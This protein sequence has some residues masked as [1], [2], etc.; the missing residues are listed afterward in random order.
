MNRPATLAGWFVGLLLLSIVLVL[1]TNFVLDLADTHTDE[2]HV[3]CLSRSRRELVLFNLRLTI[4]DKIRLVVTEPE[5]GGALVEADIGM[6]IPASLPLAVSIQDTVLQVIFRE[7]T[8]L[9]VTHSQFNHSSNDG[10]D[11]VH[12][13]NVQ[14]H[15]P[16]AHRTL[17]DEFVMSG[18]HWYGA[19]PIYEQLWPAELWDRKLSAFVA[20]DSYKDQYGGV[21]ERYWLTSRGVALYVNQDI[22]LFV[23]VNSSGSQHLSFVSHYRHPYYNQR[24]RPLRLSYRICHAVHMKSMHLFAASGKFFQRPAGVPDEQMFRYPLW[25][26][27]A[28]YKR[29]IN[30]RQVLQFAAEIRAHGFQSA[31]LEIDDGWS[32]HYGDL[33]FDQSAFPD[34]SAM[35]AQ[36]NQNG[37][38]VTLWVHPFASV[39]SEAYHETD[40]DGHSLYISD[41]LLGM[42]L[43]VVWWDG[44]AA[45]L[46]ITNPAAVA[47]FAGRLARLKSR[48][49]V[50]SFK[51]DAGE[52]SWIPSA[53]RTHLPLDNPNDYT[54]RFAE[55]AFH[56]DPY[57]RS[58]EV[59]V[60]V[61]VQRLPMFVR[62]LDKASHWGS[63]NGLRSVIPHV[64]TLGLAGYPFVLA[65]MI[66]GN[67][68]NGA[69]IWLSVLPERELFIR[70]MALTAL[71]PAMQ[72]SVPPW[73]YDGATV[74]AARRMCAL[75]ERYAG[76]MAALAEEATRTGA[77]IVRPLWWLAP[78]D[79]T[80]QTIDSQFLLGADLLVAPV[81]W[82]GALAR[83]VYLPAGRWRDELRGGVHPGNA[84]LRDYKASLYELPHFTKIA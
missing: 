83:D 42:P 27:W 55:L 3:G 36:L 16:F 40:S 25:S 4:T 84:W 56:A 38:R 79:E 6:T 82:H 77:P 72:F 26:T 52:T 78:L 67:A 68:Y 39:F 31:Q 41:N 53:G 81:V 22:P 5:R 8:T 24:Q 80:A 51:F 29:R 61:G 34:P 49:G 45:L 69:F 73:H 32:T 74:A 76:K 70:W 14:W 66:G 44:L 75:H 46:D 1:A 15:T 59:R 19:V 17:Q 30:Q 50:H 43:S 12:C 18:A 63:D 71:M 20:G 11:T 9:T 35:V 65:D 54:R 7:S 2:Q 13:Y 37:F 21:Q 57:N 60:A 64:L 23:A 62:L 47:R 10:T 28:R 58:Q 48:Y 33:E